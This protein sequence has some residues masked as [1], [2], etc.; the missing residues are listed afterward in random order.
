MHVA[1]VV[2]VEFA[3]DDIDA[4]DCAHTGGAFGACEW[5]NGSVAWDFKDAGVAFTAAQCE[6]GAAVGA[7]IAAR[8]VLGATE[9][10]DFTA[11]H[12]ADGLADASV[13]AG[14]ADV[15]GEVDSAATARLAPSAADFAAGEGVN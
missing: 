6:A 7:A 8:V 5:A 15:G 11:G 9:A 14:S 10:D 4:D 1:D 13:A 2:A 3:A 12:R